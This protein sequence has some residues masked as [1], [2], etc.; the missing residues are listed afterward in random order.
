[1]VDRPPVS[2][3]HVRRRHRSR[4]RRARLL[5]RLH[6]VKRRYDPANTFRI[7]HNIAPAHTG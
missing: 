7:N 5:R 1:M 2:Q 3:L 6:E 4:D